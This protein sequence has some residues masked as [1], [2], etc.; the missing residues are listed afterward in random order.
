MGLTRQA[1]D[2]R[3]KANK[4]IG[5]AIGRHCYV[6]P[7]WQFSRTGTLPGLKDVLHALRRHDAWSQVIF[8]LSPNDR[9]DGATPLDVLRRGQVEEVER[10]ASL[11]GEHGAV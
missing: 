4:L 1:V 7:A 2:K 6:Y 9:L 3:R 5:L 11:S 8:M 10:A